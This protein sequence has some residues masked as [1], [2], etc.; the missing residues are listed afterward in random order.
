MQDAGPASPKSLNF[1]RTPAAF[2]AVHN[3]VLAVLNDKMKQRVRVR[4]EKKNLKCTILQ[5]FILF[6]VETARIRL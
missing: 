6:K 5:L 4:K 1:I 2:N 3:L